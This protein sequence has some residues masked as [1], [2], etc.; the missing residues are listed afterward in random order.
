M[1]RDRLLVDVITDLLMNYS[2][3][4]RGRFWMYLIGD[5]RRLM[6][7]PA[8][9]RSVV[10]RLRHR[11]LLLL[12]GAPWCLAGLLVLEGSNL[13]LEL[14]DLILV[15]LVSLL[16]VI[17]VLLLMLLVLLLLLLH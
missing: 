14:Q 16:N 13:V 9:S 17:L 15:V 5:T 12:V 6:A 10:H 11:D 1:V 2:L 8:T 3:T 7:L 4:L